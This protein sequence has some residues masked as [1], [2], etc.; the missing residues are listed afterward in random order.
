MIMKTLLS[1][2]FA[3]L[4]LLQPTQARP[5]YYLYDDD[6]P[7][8]EM[9]LEMMVAMG[10]I[11]KIPPHLMGSGPYMNPYTGT[12]FAYQPGFNTPYMMQ[13]INPYAMASPPNFM[14]YGTYMNPSMGNPFT[15]PPGLNAPDM[16]QN[17]VPKTIPNPAEALTNQQAPRENESYR[18]NKI[19]LLN[20][21]WITEYGEMLG[22]KDRQFL[23]SDGNEHYLAGQ[24]H[25]Q[26][27]V[28]SLR[29]QENGLVTHY[30]YRIDQ[31]NLQTRD[32]D[33]VVRSFVKVPINQ[34]YTY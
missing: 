16:M 12:P 22:I 20:G 15:N 24:L 31:N 21:L 4:F 5:K 2:L 1:L 3:S 29:V 11:D 32:Q 19:A 28:L 13:G 33:G 17:M 8:V 10:M 18:G 30:Q 34:G 23:W 14:G 7:F 6:V 27:D 9:M 26:D 25:A